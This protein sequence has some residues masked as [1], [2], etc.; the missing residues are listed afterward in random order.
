MVNGGNT[1]E[2]SPTGIMNHKRILMKKLTEEEIKTALAQLNGWQL[3]DGWLVK[4][5]TFPN[6]KEA[7]ATMVQ[8][9]FEAEA[10]QHHP[11]WTNVYNRLEIRL[12][13]H[14]VGGIT[15][16]DTILAKTIDRLLG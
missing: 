5:V 13:T 9:S 16:K 3:A 7:M 4:K 10:Q 15:E 8:I 14:D 2:F 11:D 1:L 6:F 12:N